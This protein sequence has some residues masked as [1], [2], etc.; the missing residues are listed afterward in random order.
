MCKPPH[1]PKDYWGTFSGKICI[2]KESS[3]WPLP[4]KLGGANQTRKTQTF[5]QITI[6]S[7]QKAQPVSKVGPFL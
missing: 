1:F 4:P 5:S 7:K 3:Q 2:P 6:Y